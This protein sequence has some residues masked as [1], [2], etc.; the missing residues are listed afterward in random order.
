LGADAGDYRHCGSDRNARGS[1][2]LW[3]EELANPGNFPGCVFSGSRV[4]LWANESSTRR[5]RTT[6][7]VKEA[8]KITSTLPFVLCAAGFALFY[9]FTR[10]KIASKFWAD[11]GVV[12]F[13][14]G[15]AVLA[16]NAAGK[17]LF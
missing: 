12:C 2:L 3:H 13:A 16:W 9:V 4:L 17:S 15:L 11:V 7:K 6:R 8:V 1:V 14:I 5:G 10:P